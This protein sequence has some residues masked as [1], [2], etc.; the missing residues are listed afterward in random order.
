[1]K[2]NGMGK[3]FTFV[4]D[5]CIIHFFAVLVGVLVYSSLM[6]NDLAFSSLPT[7][8]FVFASI[9]LLTLIIFTKVPFPYPNLSLSL[10]CPT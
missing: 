6:P 1:M 3:V 7:I 5:I 4:M 2:V 9:F 8:V 10:Q